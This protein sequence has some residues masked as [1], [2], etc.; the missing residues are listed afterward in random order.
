MDR[1]PDDH[2]SDICRLSCELADALAEY[3]DAS[4][5]PYPDKLNYAIS[6]LRRVAASETADVEP[7]SNR[8]NMIQVARNA[9]SGIQSASLSVD[10]PNTR[11]QKS[12]IARIDLLIK[13]LHDEAKRV[14]NQTRPAYQGSSRNGTSREPG[15]PPEG[16]RNG[17]RQFLD[18]L[19]SRSAIFSALLSLVLGAILFS[20][21][22]GPREDE[23]AD[24]RD[25]LLMS[26][27]NLQTFLIE[28]QASLLAD[29]DQYRLAGRAA[30]R[31]TN[32]TEAGDTTTAV[33]ELE[34]AWLH[35]EQA[36]PEL[37]FSPDGNSTSTSMLDNERT[38]P[39]EGVPRPGGTQAVADPDKSEDDALVNTT[40]ITTSTSG[41]EQA[42]P[43]VVG[44]PIRE[45]LTKLANYRV[46]TVPVT[47][48]DFS[49]SQYGVVLDQT[50]TEGG[51]IVLEVAA[52][53]LGLPR[54][55]PVPL[56]VGMS[57]LDGLEMLHKRRFAVEL[58]FAGEG[59]IDLADASVIAQDPIDGPGPPE[60]TVVRVEVAPTL[61]ANL[62]TTLGSISPTT[63]ILSTSTSIVS[64]SS[65]EPETVLIPRPGLGTSTISQ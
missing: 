25:I 11:D 39:I 33:A 24:Q 29:T 62:T 10:T 38:G 63:T 58:V 44:L 49:E 6:Q 23:A 65:S 53:N 7:G 17:I 14:E 34:T 42:P 1:K 28:C 60:G 36:C 13:E 52:E 57:A 20:T 51:R 31:S 41:A 2:N 22:T 3:C 16:S 40:E 47:A 21:C 54:P 18:S 26:R 15:S 4:P 55:N 61:T 35:A 19:N 56:V 5:H 30:E 48:V 9:V 43:D 59:P 45:A 8:V 12:R 37:V 27:S 64:T 50:E 46:E 32:A